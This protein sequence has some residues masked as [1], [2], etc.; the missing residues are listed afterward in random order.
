MDGEGTVTQE[1]NV[2]VIYASIT[3]TEKPQDLNRLII[4]NMLKR[5]GQVDPNSA[6]YQAF[7]QDELDRLRLAVN[8][9]MYQHVPDIRARYEKIR[10]LYTE[11]NSQLPVKVEF[12]FMSAFFP[13]FA[14]MDAIGVDYIGFFSDYVRTNEILIRRNTGISES[15]GFMSKILH[16]SGIALQNFKDTQKKHT[17]AE[18]LVNRTWR[19]ELNNT[20]V[21]VFY[22]EA[23][24]LMLFNLEQVITNLLSSYSRSSTGITA[25]GLRNMLERH[26][27]ALTPQEIVSSGIMRRAAMHMGAG[28]R[29]SDVVVFRGQHWLNEYLENAKTSDTPIPTNNVEPPDEQQSEDSSDGTTVDPIVWY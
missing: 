3:G 4:I 21:G 13:L 1:Y 20:G 26:K 25:M 17:L 5:E 23:N 29:L 10:R 8:F 16:F 12:R 7:P 19:Q 6:I 15:D 28:L 2:P 18:V 11:I 27:A 9:G 24:H 22:D 14:V